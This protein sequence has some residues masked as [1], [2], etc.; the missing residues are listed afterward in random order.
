MSGP[1]RPRCT[2]T[3]NCSPSTSSRASSA[4]P[5]RTIAA[6]QRAIGEWEEL[7]DRVER[8]VAAAT[9]KHQ[10]ERVAT[11]AAAGD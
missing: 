7:G 1:A 11:M 10:A 2:A 5:A 6:E 4:S 9:E 8:A 3:T